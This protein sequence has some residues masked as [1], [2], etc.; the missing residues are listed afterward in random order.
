MDLLA[1]VLLGT[2]QGLTEFLPVSSSAH[3]ILARAFFGWDAGRYG[4]AFDVALHVGTFLAVLAFFR[5]DVIEMLA[6]SPGALTM[7]EGSAERLAR[8]VV[9]G[10]VPVVIVGLLFA[11]R[12]EE[13]RDPRVIAATLAIGGLGLV[14]GEKLG[15]HRRSE[16][17]VTYWEALAIGVA[18]ASAL[19]PGISR[20]G[21]TLTVA[22]L[23][24]L[25][26]PGAARF[27][28]LLSLPA[29]LAAAAK[30]TLDMM[31]AGAADLPVE[32]F[33]VGFVVSTVVGYLTIK[34]FLR[35]LA[36][37]SLTAFAVYRFAL[38]AVTVV[39]LV[40]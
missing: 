28:F 2:V 10:T 33:V 39:W 32:M 15:S 6:A 30:E 34:Y 21:A 20:S 26:R 4:L 37:H 16:D 9:V 27:V 13:V 24:G 38:A 3:L 29:V 17:T 12:L 35:Y 25:T 36:N 5:R 8:L 23:L 22:L 19:I 31:Q 18:Q 14:L 40:S 11:D 1:A 7:R